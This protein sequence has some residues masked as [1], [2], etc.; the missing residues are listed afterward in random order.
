MNIAQ[1]SSLADESTFSESKR[2]RKENFTESKKLFLTEL[3]KAHADILES[4]SIDKVKLK[5]KQCLDG[6]RHH[7][8]LS[9]RWKTKT[10]HVRIEGFVAAP[11][12]CG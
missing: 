10:R 9:I 3:V 4:K 1:M 11:E 5:Q 8:Q 12:D 6:N 7:I 2:Q